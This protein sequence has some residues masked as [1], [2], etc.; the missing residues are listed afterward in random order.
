M[1][2]SFLAHPLALL[3]ATAALLAATVGPR[4]GRFRNYLLAGAAVGALAMVRPLDAV[5]AAATLASL[6][7]L[8]RR[9]KALLLTGAAVAPFVILLLCYNRT[10]TGST[11]LFPPQL[12]NALDTLGFCPGLG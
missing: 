5:V 11:F 1:G 8:R 10:L 9:G 3:L 4:P 12:Y 2:A 7:L 6:L